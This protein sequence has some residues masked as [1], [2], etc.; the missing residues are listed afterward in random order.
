M[1][2]TIYCRLSQHSKSGTDDSISNQEQECKDFCARYNLPIRATYK[3][4]LTARGDGNYET[5]NDVIQQM[6]AGDTLV[7]YDITRFSRNTLTGLE[8]LNKISALGLNIR[9]VKEG[10][11][12]VTIYDK[13]S[14][15]HYLD[16]SEFESDQKSDR[17]KSANRYRRSR[18]IASTSRLLKYG[19]ERSIEGGVKKVRRSIDEFNNIVTIRRM[20][21][22]QTPMADILECMNATSTYRGGK[23]T[24]NIV[25]KV[26]KDN[27]D[28][29]IDLGELLNDATPDKT[30]SDKTV[31]DKTVSDKTVLLEPVNQ[32]LDANPAKRK[33]IN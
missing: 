22:S 8:L 29:P 21:E 9:T 20:I 25:V 4:V 24:N 2:A 18:G 5:L 14:F 7:I 17:Q 27:S 26:Y 13:H 33:K 28:K 6:T 16:M 23:W 12:Y 19:Y 1:S 30:V 32:S 15:R 3:F 11:S 10:L 31:S